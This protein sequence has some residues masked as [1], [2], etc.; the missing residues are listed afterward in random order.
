MSK[1]WAS[2]LRCA[3]SIWRLTRRS[4]MTSSSFMPIMR[5]AFCT[6]SEAKMRI[7]LSSSDR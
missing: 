5:M 7:R 4:S 2:T 3:F 1:L 6:Q